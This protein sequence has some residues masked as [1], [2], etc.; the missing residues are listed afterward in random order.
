[1]DL[2]KPVTALVYHLIGPWWERHLNMQIIQKL[3]INLIHKCLTTV[4]LLLK[5]FSIYPHVSRKPEVQYVRRY[6]HFLLVDDSEVISDYSAAWDNTQLLQ[7]NKN[8]THNNHEESEKQAKA[9]V[10]FLNKD[11][12]FWLAVANTDM[13]FLLTT[14]IHCDCSIGVSLLNMVVWYWKW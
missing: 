5:E 1:M 3:W 13:A 12:C 14:S 2:H 4:V 11:F 7:G 6:A 9:N 10:H 8:D